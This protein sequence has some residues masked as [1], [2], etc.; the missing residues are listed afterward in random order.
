[1]RQSRPP[2]CEIACSE[3]RRFQPQA[4][5]LLRGIP[6]LW[7]RE[8]MRALPFPKERRA[9]TPDEENVLRQ[10]RSRQSPARSA[11]MKPS[12][13]I[14][15]ATK[16]D[17]AVRRGPMRLRQKTDLAAR[18]PTRIDFEDARAPRVYKACRQIE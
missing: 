9:Q 13:S 16:R 7:G 2:L 6:T 18:K 3:P 8:P 17:Y 12:I 4:K 10:R 1:M 11:Q 14:V 5:S 15:A